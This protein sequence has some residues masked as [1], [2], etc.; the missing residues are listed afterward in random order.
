MLQR[1]LDKTQPEPLCSLSPGEPEL[2]QSSGCPSNPVP[3]DAGPL[4]QNTY[5]FVC[6]MLQIQR[7]TG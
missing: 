4:K 1:T 6:L 5:N 3:D 2:A 7:E